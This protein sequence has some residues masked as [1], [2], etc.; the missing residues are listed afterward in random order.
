MNDKQDVQASDLHVMVEGI[1]NCQGEILLACFCSPED[2]MNMDR[3]FK[4]GSH[5]CPTQGNTVRFTL[6]SC[7]H[8]Q[9]ACC[10]LIDS[11]ANQKMDFNILGYP[12]EAFAFSN[13]AVGRF[14]PPAFAEAAFAHNG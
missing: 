12:L 14:G 10:V 6:S 11:N 13:D 8:G 1:Q 7:P 2:W 4:G 3:L 9:Y 5:P